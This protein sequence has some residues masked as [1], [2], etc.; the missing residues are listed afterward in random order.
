MKV[1]TTSSYFLI[2]FS[3]HLIS[4]EAAILS[5]VGLIYKV[6]SIERSCES[7]GL[8]FTFDMTFYTFLL[9]KSV[10]I[11]LLFNSSKKKEENILL[12]SPSSF[13]IHNNFVFISFF[14]FLR[15]SPFIVISSFIA[16]D[17]TFV[18]LFSV[19]CIFP[20]DYFRPI[21]T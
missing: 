1:F 2:S 7:F 19:Y 6:C 17:D 21:W 5:C 8:V 11:Y 3:S 14:S 9:C 10:C 13:L 18:R 15:L 16:Y 20:S 4:S 12:L